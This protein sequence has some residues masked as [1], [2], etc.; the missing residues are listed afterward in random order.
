VFSDAG[1][2]RAEDPVVVRG[3][4]VGKVRELT[5][6]KDGVHVAAT[7]DEPIRPRAGYRIAVVTTS[8]LG[9][10]HMEI[11]EGPAGEPLPSDTVF[12]GEPPANL[13]GDAAEV[14]SAVRRALI[15]GGMVSNLQEA[16]SQIRQITERA[17][18]GQGTLGRLLSSDDSL[19]TN[20]A[21]S[22]ASL[23]NIT[24]RLDAG[25]GTLGKLLSSDDKLYQDLSDTVSSLKTV[26]GRIERGEGTL[27]RLLSSDDKLYRDLSDTMA[28]LKDITYRMNQGE[29]T[30]GRL[31]KDDDLYVDVKRTVEELRQ[32]IDDFRENT[33]VVTFS[34]I[35]FGA[36]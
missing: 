19:Y 9:G 33:P 23:K 34:S 20:L 25:Q 28:S 7:L 29:G 24:Q 26:S 17:N 30:V 31:L 6:A 4:P 35:V 32:A 1:G 15:Q 36:F 8:I 13:M 14:M 22:V 3:M 11:D 27:G 12:H 2:L 16:A 5:L 21:S 18:S 10:R